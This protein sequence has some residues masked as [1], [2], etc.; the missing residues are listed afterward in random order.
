MYTIDARPQY[1][2]KR[3]LWP[4]RAA[5]FAVLVL[6]CGMANASLAAEEI[7]LR[8]TVTVHWGDPVPGLDGAPQ[9]R[10]L[11]TE[12][13]G[14]LWQ[15]ELDDKMVAAMG[16]DLALHRSF[17]AVI[18]QRPDPDEYY[19]VVDEVGELAPVD[20]RDTQVFGPQP[21][22]WIL[23]RFGDNSST[24]ELPAWFEDQAGPGLHSL[25]EY[26]RENSF[27]QINLDGSMVVGWYDLPEP[28][29][30]YVYDIDGDG[31]LDV[32]F[33]RARED[34]VALAD[35][36][37]YFPDFV[38]INLIFNGALDCCA[39]GGQGNFVLDGVSRT[40][41]ITYMPPGGWRD[42]G[43]LAHEMGHAFSLPH[44]SGPYGATYDSQW[45]VMSSA[46][47]TCTLEDPEYGCL[48]PH[49]ISYHKDRLEWIPAY[50]RHET[51]SY[52]EVS[53]HTMHDLA[54]W[55][56]A[57]TDQI[58]RMSLWQTAPAQFYTIEARRLTG[59]DGNIPDSAVLMHHVDTT[60]G[61][62]ALVVDID[63]DGD[64]NDDGAIWVSGESFVDSDNQIV[65]TVETE[66]VSQ[67]VITITNA[68]RT[69]VYVDGTHTG[70]QNGSST[71][72]WDT[73]FEGYGGAYPNGTVYIEPG[74]Y[75]QP[76]TFRKPATLR[77]WGTGTVEIG[78]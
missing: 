20:D 9:R 27:D 37:V 62:H 19:V 29:S 4:S 26:Y 63:G 32:N 2:H 54:V 69:Y 58:V 59:Y 13:N 72:P 78:G 45:D 65:M 11:L 77:P 49:T 21:Y 50:A 60:R 55:P 22:V 16:G 43:I 7:T 38:G 5:K 51:A 12:D 68:A 53:S 75:N 52:P 36:D 33:T 56:P 70:Y 57:G 39:W 10:H 8:G 28:R 18:G 41:G 44:S 74:V 76:M 24:P 66:M 48:A 23:L 64:C 30:Y 1:A 67:N 3:G 14:T 31:D 46:M 71:Y 15:L 42:H 61:S 47:G 35:S 40:W 34:A 6:A 73:V 17:A 25:D